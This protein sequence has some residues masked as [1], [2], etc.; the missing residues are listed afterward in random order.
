MITVVTVALYGCGAA[1][2]M[3]KKHKLDVQTKMSETV[4]LEPT[5]PSKK[6]IFVSVRNT[7][8]TEMNIKKQIVDLLKGS[9]YTITKDPEK[10]NFMLQAN[11]LKLGKTDLRSS[12]TYLKAGYGG[13]VI[14]GALGG[15]AS[16]D[17]KGAAAG[18]LIVGISSLIGD[19]LVEDTYY[20]MVTDLQVRERPRKGERVQQRQLLST[21]QGTATGLQQK[22]TGGDIDWKTYRTRIVSTANKANLQFDEARPKLEKGLTLSISGI[23]A[24]EPG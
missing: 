15:V 7:T 3:I 10:A 2:T 13:A 5:A 6:I 23:F 21:H 12:K 24:E 17:S 1:H 8:D 4:F 18:A 20:S 14:G 11:I 16:E 22:V 19:A 9:S